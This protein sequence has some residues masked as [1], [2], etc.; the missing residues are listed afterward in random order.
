MMSK[1]DLERIDRSMQWLMQNDKP[2]GGKIVI[3]SGDFRQILPVESKPVDSINT[4][5]KK[6][7]LWINGTIKPLSLTINERVRQFGGS[8]TYATFLMYVGL[9]LLKTKKKKQLIRRFKEYTDEFVRFPTRIGQTQ[10][11]RNF[12]GLDGFVDVIFPNLEKSNHVPKSVILTPKN[13]NM[14]VINEMCLKRFRPDLEPIDP[15]LSYDK[16]FI[17]E[18]GKI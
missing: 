9:G 11:V 8:D 13:K 4:C 10:I 17:P 6:S 7:Y 12:D 3:L 14:N 15:I 1:V 2:F 18:Q 16:P 5:M